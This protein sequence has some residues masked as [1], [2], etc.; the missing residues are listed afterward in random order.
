MLC[1]R[2]GRDNRPEAS[3]CRGCGQ[4]LLLACPNCGQTLDPD[5]AF[6]DGCGTR[7]N[8]RD[9]G[10]PGVIPEQPA[11]VEAQGHVVENTGD[12]EFVVILVELK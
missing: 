2:C 9:G 12:A 3:F 5:D 7:V 8:S 11:F 4:A 1:R 10:S 6:C